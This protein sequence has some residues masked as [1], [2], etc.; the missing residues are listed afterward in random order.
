MKYDIQNDHGTICANFN[1]VQ[2]F[3]FILKNFSDGQ[4]ATTVSTF[5]FEQ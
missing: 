1:N 2:T 5:G 3:L 4:D